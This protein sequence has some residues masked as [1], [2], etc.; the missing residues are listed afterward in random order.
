MG[1]TKYK[2]G[3]LIERIDRRN[4]DLHYGIED[5]RGVSNAKQI[6]STRAD[7]S[8]RAL[9]RFL[10]IQPKEFVFN[11][12]T[13]RMGERI[14][15]GFNDTDRAFIFTEDYVA[16]SVKASAANT[17]LPEYLYIFFLRNE[18]DRYVRYDSWGSAT[19]FFN[20]EEMCDVP[21]KLPSKDIQ[22]K[23][24]DV[25]SAMLANQKAYERGLDDLKLACDAYIDELRRDLPHKAIREYLTPS[26]ERNSLGLGADAVRGIATSKE[27]IAT[28]ADLEGVGL[29]N[30]KV[31]RP[32]Y[33]AYVADTSRRGEKISLAMNTTEERYLVSSISTV[34][35]TNS[36]KLSPAYLMMFFSRSEFDRY[37]RFHSWGS[38]REA[39]GW[40]DMQD[41]KI[42]IP[43][44]DVQKSIVNIYN[45]YLTRREINEK[46]KAQIKAICPI[47][48]KGSL[49]EAKSA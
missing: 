12:R 43:D 27:I 9:D 22:Q 48:I 25:Y 26:D 7:I 32:N 4:S 35:C 38:A 44:I 40:E 42:P 23:Y 41:V 47:L 29:S 3:A 17:L 39:F 24:V 19:E 18:F 34:F 31:M 8:E 11:R 14:G 36:K 20:W 15:L 16:F 37:A 45:A 1:L 30:Y 5:V 6:M 2:L 13:T 10:I 21:I 49:E 46:L 33:I 28:K